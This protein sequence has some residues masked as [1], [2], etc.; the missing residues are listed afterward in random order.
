MKALQALDFHSF[1]AENAPS[2]DPDLSAARHAS[3]QAAREEYSRI[4]EAIAATREEITAWRQTLARG[5]LKVVS[6][7]AEPSAPASPNIPLHLLGG[8]AAGLVLGLI[9][10]LVLIPILHVV[11]K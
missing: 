4:E 10:P 11:K 3:L 1:Q 7:P 9:A 8:I 6:P 2:D 5:D